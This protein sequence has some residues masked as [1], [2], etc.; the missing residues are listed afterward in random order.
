MFGEEKRAGAFL[1]KQEVKFDEAG[2]DLPDRP[3]A[4]HLY[5]GSAKAA[6]LSQWLNAHPTWEGS[7]VVFCGD[8]NLLPGVFTEIR[9]EGRLAKVTLPLLD[10]LSADPLTQKTFITIL[11]SILNHQ[12][13]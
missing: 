3:E 9:G 10:N 7:L 4:G 13:P 6:D 11:A 5:V 8:A 2:T 12:T 1:E